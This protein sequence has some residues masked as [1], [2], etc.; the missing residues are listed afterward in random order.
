M[1]DYGPV[2]TGLSKVFTMQLHNYKQVPC[3]WTVKRPV[4]ASKAK[5]WAYFSVEP[6]E[7]VLEPDQKVN[8]KVVFT[9]VLGRESPYV[10][11][12]GVGGVNIYISLQV[13]EMD[14][15]E[16]NG[17]LEIKSKRCGE[18]LLASV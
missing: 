3:E 18:S 1:M 7:G 4:E 17:A 13:Y 12:C 10:Q 2:Q 14:H 15:M 16:A 11:V 6:P 9:P 8:V 5:D